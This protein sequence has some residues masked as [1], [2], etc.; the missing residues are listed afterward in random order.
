MCYRTRW[1]RVPTPAVR[2]VTERFSWQNG[3]SPSRAHEGN[4]WFK[5]TA[6]R[7]WWQIPSWFKVWVALAAQAASCSA[8]RCQARDRNETGD[9]H[10]LS[11][12]VNAEF[13]MQAEAWMLPGGFPVGQFCSLLKVNTSF[14][15]HSLMEG[16]FCLLVDAAISPMLGLVVTSVAA[17]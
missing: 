14:H 12:P 9:L 16:S 15:S 13:Y 17:V 8:A 5:G 11:F 1:E 2:V 10:V 7:S 3:E 4:K 6:R